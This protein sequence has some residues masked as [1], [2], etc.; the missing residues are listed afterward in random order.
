VSG[1]P[2][3][4]VDTSTLV[5]AALGPGSAAGRLL[6]RLIEDGQLVASLETIAEADA[7]LGRPK[8]AAR[9]PEAVRRRFLRRL[10]LGAL[11]VEPGERISDCRDPEDDKLLEAALAG[12]S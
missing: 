6:D 7:V 11:V 9:L 5:R 12:G 2:R 4:F 3:V 8:L 10:A 1:P